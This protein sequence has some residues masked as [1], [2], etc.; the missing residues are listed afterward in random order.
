MKANKSNDGKH[1]Y[2]AICEAR[3]DTVTRW[4]KVEKNEK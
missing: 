2:C 4:N 3:L 1:Y